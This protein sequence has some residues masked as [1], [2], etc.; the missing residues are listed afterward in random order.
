MPTSEGRVARRRLLDLIFVPDG[1][2][3]LVLIV[4]PAGFGKSRLLVDCAAELAAR[5]Q[6]ATSLRCE[7]H[8]SGADGFMQKLHQSLTESG[9][10]DDVAG[11]TL[12]EIAARLGS[13]RTPGAILIDDFNIVASPEVSELLESLARCLVPGCQL[14][15]ASRTPPA[16]PIAKLCSSGLVTLLEAD[17]L[18]FTTAEAE[19][20]LR[21][22]SDGSDRNAIV[23]QAEGWPV[24]L[25]LARLRAARQPRDQVPRRP[26]ELPRH[27]VLDY[28]ATEV[29]GTID[30]ALQA[31]LVET[32]I[33]ETIE[34]KSADAVRGTRDSGRHILALNALRPI[35][36]VDQQPLRARLHPLFRE[37]L[38]G[39]L[40]SEH[41]EDLARLHHGAAEHYATVGLTIL[42]TEHAIAA[43]APDL[44]ARIVESAGAV[45]LVVNETIERLERLIRLLPS[46]LLQARPR[47]KMLC[48]VQRLR[49]ELSPDAAAEL[50]AFLQTATSPEGELASDLALDVELARVLALMVHVEQFV[51]P[52]WRKEVERAIEFVRAHPRAD[53]RTLVMVLT[54]EV[55]LLVRFGPFDRAERRAQ[56][57]E[58]LVRKT[59]GHWNLLFAWIHRAC[60]SYRRGDLRAAEQ[61]L[62][63]VLRREIEVFGER[64]TVAG[65]LA[66]AFLGKI[67]YLQDATDTAQAHFSAIAWPQPFI[68]L[69]ALEA[70]TLWQ[71]RLEFAQH[72]PRRALATLTAAREEAEDRGLVHLR[73]LA[74]A[75]Q[76]EILAQLGRLA[77]ARSIAGEIP[78]ETWSELARSEAVLPFSSV[79]AIARAR[80]HLALIEKHYDQA[81]EYAES[82]T[83]QA[84]A[85]SARLQVCTGLLL[86]AVVHRAM[87]REARAE[88]ALL[89]ALNASCGS[90][91]VRLFIDAAAGL[92]TLV[93]RIAHGDVRIEDMTPEFWS[94]PAQPIADAGAIRAW[95]AVVANAILGSSESLG[96]RLTPREREVLFALS[97]FGSTKR[98]ARELALSPETIRYHLRSIFNK[99]GVHSRSAALEIANREG[100][101]A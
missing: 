98:M 27:Q 55:V 26:F 10:I 11:L 7:P 54:V 9:L 73:T 96:P 61:S 46:T 47:L 2:A 50:D 41:H 4:A 58:A 77:E 70:P 37:F 49:A 48:I 57:L 101:L 95:A 36:E 81:L 16:L 29:Y 97:R 93:K 100:W 75:G 39:R 63:R 19:E 64:Q 74:M 22:V 85:L 71:A 5:G 20:L 30:P 68:S 90:G 79:E 87:G 13:L 6:W 94:D 52:E 45:H 31:F 43:G 56:T 35:V 99:L 8:D 1:A 33:L 88:R 66:N 18:R 67:Y 65:C 82:L 38:R 92:V 44:A 17:D 12:A 80:F 24:I 34:P 83:A 42:A 23:A 28:C 21:D 91:A 84:R 25:Q 53:D 62:L 76:M 72:N 3:P 60:A 51:A 32:S 14:I 15:V 40:E 89:A 69:E 78:I 86:S 59:E